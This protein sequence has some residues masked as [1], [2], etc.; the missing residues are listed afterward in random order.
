FEPSLYF[1]PRNL[2]G[3][4]ARGTLAVAGFRY[5]AYLLTNALSAESDV[6]AGTLLFVMVSNLL[7]G[8]LVTYRTNSIAASGGLEYLFTA[9]CQP[10]TVATDL[11]PGPCGSGA[12]ANLPTTFDCVGSAASE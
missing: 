1:A 11:P 2:V 4:V 9:S 10:P 6:T 8:L 5:G 12:T 3:R 7:T